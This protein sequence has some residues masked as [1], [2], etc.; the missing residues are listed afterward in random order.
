MQFESSP[1]QLKACWWNWAAGF[2][3][4]VGLAAR[5]RTCPKISPAGLL[6]VSFHLHPSIRV[7]AGV[8]NCSTTWPTTGWGLESHW[9]YWRTDRRACVLAKAGWSGPPGAL[10]QAC[11]QTGSGGASLKEGLTGSR[12]LSDD[13]DLVKWHK[14]QRICLILFFWMW[15]R[16]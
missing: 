10:S 1:V 16:R 2:S 14:R 11:A 8:A 6:G 12:G 4:A 9:L 15:N 13:P 5:M 7:W 3:F